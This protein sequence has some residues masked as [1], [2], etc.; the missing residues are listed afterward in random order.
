MSGVKGRSGRK[1]TSLIQTG[2]NLAVKMRTP[3][4]ADRFCFSRDGIY[5]GD[6]EF[7]WWR[8]WDDS[9]YGWSGQFDII[10][11]VELQHRLDAARALGISVFE[12][13]QLL[14]DV[15]EHE[16]YEFFAGNI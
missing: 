12:K 8:E 16:C 14:G 7:R 11:K 6:G 10:T 13:F 15:P 1:S 2:H 4:R 3:I 5:S 9:G